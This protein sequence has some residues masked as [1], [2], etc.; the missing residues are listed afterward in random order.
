M[1]ASSPGQKRATR[2]CDS[3]GYTTVCTES[4]PHA[5]GA[6]TIWLCDLCYQTQAS[7]IDLQGRLDQDQVL[8]HVCAVGNALID[9]F[10]GDRSRMFPP[11]P[12]DV[13]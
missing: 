1:S 9:A 4:G 6:E 13:G 3:C 12:E 11:D 8:S 7:R 5:P 10:G 2:R